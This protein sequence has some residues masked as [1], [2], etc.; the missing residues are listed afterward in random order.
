MTRDTSAPRSEVLGAVQTRPAGAAGSADA[1]PE[2]STAAAP[3]VPRRRCPRLISWLRCR[4]CHRGYFAAGAPDP[5]AC[6]ACAGGRLQPVG[7]WAL[8]HEGAPLG[9]LVR[10]V[11]QEV[12]A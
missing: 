5:Q 2:Y 10:P 9:M 1:V 7:T 8:A 4:A 12:R 11:V 3:G 6:P